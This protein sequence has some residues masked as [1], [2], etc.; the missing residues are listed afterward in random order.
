MKPWKDVS[1]VLVPPAMQTLAV[2]ARGYRIPYTATVG[3]DGKPDFRVVDTVKSR[4][5]IVYRLCAVCGQPMGEQ[6]AF[7]GGPRTMKNHL[8]F[9]TAMHEECAVYALQVC[10]FLAAPKFS[11]ARADIKMVMPL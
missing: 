11:Y 2:D 6:I 3:T 9:D 10:P 8:F 1:T 5:C 4:R 7:V